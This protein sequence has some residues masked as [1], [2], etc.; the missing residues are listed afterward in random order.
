MELTNVER[1]ERGSIEVRQGKV[2]RNTETNHEEKLNCLA[3][4]LCWNDVYIKPYHRQYHKIVNQCFQN[5]KLLVII[6]LVFVI[7]LLIL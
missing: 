1:F 5:N 7:A 3:K 4:S 6:T 2:R